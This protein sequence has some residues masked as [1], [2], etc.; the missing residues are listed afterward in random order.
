MSKRKNNPQSPTEPKG[1]AMSAPATGP[2]PAAI[3]QAQGE[4]PAP[5]MTAT[6]A[7]VNA[8]GQAQG[9]TPA[10]QLAP[11]DPAKGAA[12]RHPR[13][14]LAP[15]LLTLAQVAELTGD[16]P[17]TVRRWNDTGKMPRPV[18]APSGRGTGAYKRPR[19]PAGEIREWI[20]AG[21]PPRK[22][23][24]AMKADARAMATA[25]PSAKK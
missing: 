6:P 18:Y 9:E 25:K 8:P 5:A 13:P 21:M 2:A 14:R 4:T 19:F 23:W 7:T 3:G 11:I 17:E 16:S 12:P 15:M 22:E 10:A 20:N 24:E 1:D